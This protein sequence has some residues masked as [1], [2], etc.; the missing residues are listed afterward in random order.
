MTI[1]Q[2]KQYLERLEKN[3]L[4]DEACNVKTYEQ[5]KELSAWV[6]LTENGNPNIQKRAI[7]IIKS[8]R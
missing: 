4:R 3:K 2:C 5:A 7:K 1:D 8:F 6:S